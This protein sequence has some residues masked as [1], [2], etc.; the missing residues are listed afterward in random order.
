MQIDPVDFADTVVRK[1]TLRRVLPEYVAAVAKLRFDPD[2]N[3]KGIG[4]FAM[5]QTDWDAVIK[6]EAVLSEFQP[7]D[8]NR[9]RMQVSVFSVMAG[10][11]QV[12]LAEKL[13]RDISMIELY[14]EQW[15]AGQISSADLDVALKAVEP[16]ITTAMKKLEDEFAAMDNPPGMSV[17]DDAP[18]PS[19]AGGIMGE[20]IASV[21][22]KG[23]YN[24]FNKGTAGVSG[25]PQNFTTMSIADVMAKQAAKQVFAVGKYQL[26]P[27]TMKETVKRLAIDTSRPYSPA[28]QEHMFRHY[29]ISGKRPRFKRYIT[30]E[31]SDINKAQFDLANEF[32]SLPDPKTGKSV[33]A[34]VGGNAA[35]VSTAKL[36]AAMNAER[37]QYADL[38]NDKGKSPDEAW[39]ALSP[40]LV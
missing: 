4:P 27:V 12:A 17:S 30:G 14:N 23:N 40:G 34:G 20:L 2:S 9:W 26:I 25:A 7:N 6:K 3:G 22:S 35:L 28:M 5:N 18:M 10:I 11:A 21:E 1:A 8:I 36:Q 19:G 15:P 31:D 29:L 13:G 32:A 38:K 16:S 33:F 24:A 37:A 39:T